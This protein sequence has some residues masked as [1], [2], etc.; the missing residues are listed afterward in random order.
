M[1]VLPYTI[2]SKN[3]LG[4]C[5][6]TD[7]SS[8][9]PWNFYQKFIFWSPIFI[10]SLNILSPSYQHLLYKPTRCLQ[11]T[12]FIFTCTLSTDGDAHQC[13]GLYMICS[14]WSLR[15][16]IWS[17][18]FRFPWEIVP[19]FGA[20]WAASSGRKC[21]ILG[22][23]TTH[24]LR[25]TLRTSIWMRFGATSTQ[26]LRYS[27]WWLCSDW[28]TIYQFKSFDHLQCQ[29]RTEVLLRGVIS[30]RK[31]QGFQGIVVGIQWAYLCSSWHS[32]VQIC[33]TDWVPVWQSSL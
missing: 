30:S 9:L 14:Y 21:P 23:Q 11:L 26:K 13:T 24:R 31:A 5:L 4:K 27:R 1:R 29:D 15:V 18:F 25:T 17:L 12:G 32:S 28:L 7:Q 16:E 19:S 6:V 10:S 22:V 33:K 3:C 2:L 8:N 20:K